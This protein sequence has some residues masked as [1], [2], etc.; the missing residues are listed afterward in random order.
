MNLLCSYDVN[1][2]LVVYSFFPLL[3]IIKDIFLDMDLQST[4]NLFYVFTVNTDLANTEP[5]LLGKTGSE[6]C[7]PLVSTFLSTDE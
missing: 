3:C 2:I 6:S 4:I 7:K 5:L 1:H